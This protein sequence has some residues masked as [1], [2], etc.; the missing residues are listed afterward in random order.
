LLRPLKPFQ[1][2]AH[3][4]LKANNPESYRFL[5]EKERLQSVLVGLQEQYEDRVSSLLMSG[6]R[7]DE[8]LEMVVPERLGS[9]EPPE[10]EDEGADY[11]LV[12]LSANPPNVVEEPEEE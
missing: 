6:L 4:N 12:R 5:V 2:Q 9:L 3:D 1:K 7:P 8:A 11:D 10:K